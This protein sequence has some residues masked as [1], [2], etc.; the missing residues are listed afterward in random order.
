M[1][2]KLEIRRNLF[3]SSYNYLLNIMIGIIIHTKF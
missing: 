2:L 3:K 1:S